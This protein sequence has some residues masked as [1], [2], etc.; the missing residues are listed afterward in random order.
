MGFEGCDVLH[1]GH[2]LTNTGIE[3][4][5]E[6]RPVFKIAT[7]LIRFHIFETLICAKYDHLNGAEF[8]VDLLLCVFRTK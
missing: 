4:R 3:G 5:K 7:A 8:L 2:H 1:D 6:G